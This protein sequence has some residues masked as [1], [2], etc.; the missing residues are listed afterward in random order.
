MNQEQIKSAIRWMVTM[1]GAGA[2][3]WMAHTGFMTSQQAM[4]ILN[5]PVFL[6]IATPI[7]M[8]IW[9][10]FTHTQ[11]NAVQVVKEIAKD[12]TSPV[13]GIVTTDNVA[14][15]ELANSMDAPAVVAPAGTVAASTIAKS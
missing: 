2:A 4:D 1:F 14:G 13:A 9:S 5:S 10:L 6:S 12:P 15:R 8:G 3:G 11:A 7:A